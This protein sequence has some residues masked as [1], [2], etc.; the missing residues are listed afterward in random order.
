MPRDLVMDYNSLLYYLIQVPNWW[1][2]G[3]AKKHFNMRM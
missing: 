2:G 1:A 3:E